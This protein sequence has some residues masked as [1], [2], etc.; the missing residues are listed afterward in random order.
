MPT[1]DTPPPEHWE[2]DAGEAGV[3]QLDIPPDAVRDRRF[4]VF[5]SLSVARAGEGGEAWQQ[6]RVLVNGSQEWLRREPTHEGGRDSLDYR[7]RRVVPAGEPL[8]V[9]AASELYRARRIGLVITAD[10]D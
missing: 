3:A 4:E 2:A 1:H 5:C 8:R 10:E 9:S 7:F 6:M